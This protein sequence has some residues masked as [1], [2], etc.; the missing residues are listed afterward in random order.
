MA[1]EYPISAYPRDL[2][3][4]VRDR[5]QNGRSPGCASLPDLPVLESLISVCYQASLLREEGR[6]VRFRLILLPPDRLP[7]DLGPP[8]GLHRLLFRDTLPFTERELR[9][10]SPSLDFYGSLIGLA[11]DEQ[12]QLSIWGIVHSGSRWT[13]SLHGGGKGFQPLPDALVISVTNPGR[14]TVSN[15]SVEIATLHSGK[16]LGPSIAVFDSMRFRSE[17]GPI[18]NSIANEE[19]ALHLEARKRADRPWAAIDPEFFRTL[20]KQISMRVL[21]RIRSYGHGG[22]LILVPNELKEAFL[23]QDYYSGSSTSSWTRSRAAAFAR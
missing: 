21:G 5:W 16:I 19:I 13:Q 7:S 22:T 6:P 8:A 4:F 9:K 17:F 14:I 15:G 1:P 18:V 10:L 23:S 20:K 11:H 2:A 3:A 12:G